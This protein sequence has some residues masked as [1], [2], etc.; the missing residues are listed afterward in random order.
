MDILNPWFSEF[1]AVF[2]LFA[3]VLA[4]IGAGAFFSEQKGVLNARFFNSKGTLNYAAY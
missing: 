4:P 2:L 3:P 1:I